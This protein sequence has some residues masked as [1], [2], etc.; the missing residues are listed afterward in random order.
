MDFRPGE[1]YQRPAASGASWY[2]DALSEVREQRAGSV[3]IQIEILGGGEVRG[4]LQGVS[5]PP[6]GAHGAI[7]LE[8][9]QAIPCEDIEAFT[10][11]P[12]PGD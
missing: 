11:L 5:D 1:R 4:L 9:G 10:L 3:P 12:G 2:T 7:N 6:L 8:S